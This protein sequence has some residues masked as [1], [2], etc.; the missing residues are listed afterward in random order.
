MSSYATAYLDD[1]RE[2]CAFRNSVDERILMLFT[3]DDWIELE[4]DEA[5]RF[6]P[7]YPIDEARVVGFHASAATLRDRLNLMGVSVEVVATQLAELAKYRAEIIE[8]LPSASYVLDAEDEAELEYLKTLTWDSWLT[9]LRQG[10]ERGE[11]VENWGTQEPLGTASRQMAIWDEGDLDPRA[12]LRAILEALPADAMVILDVADVVEGG[13]IDTPTDPQSIGRSLLIRSSAGLLPPVVLVEGRFDAEVLSAAL[14]LRRPHLAKY[15]RLP[16]FSHKHESNAVALRQ[17]VRAFAA[18]GIP[19]R[20]LALFDNDAAAR[21][22]LQ[23]VAESA[24]PP[25]IQVT[26][27]PELDLAKNYPTVGPQGRQ[28]MDVNGL[29]TSIELF[30]GRDVLTHDGSLLPVQWRNY[31]PGIGAYHGDLLDKPLAQKRFREKVSAA[32]KSPQEL[33]TQDWSGLD[34]VLDHIVSLLGRAS[35]GN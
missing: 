7:H 6:V 9:Q 26:R 12:R 24:L 11:P 35:A 13:W 20:V 14:R 16:D 21:E 2:I 19:N 18:A 28:I 27:L 29:A 8:S 31:S 34:L 23:S 30:L 22:A 1:G 17:T 25:N 33:A 10:V 15:V 3:Q 4:G 32:T 5:V